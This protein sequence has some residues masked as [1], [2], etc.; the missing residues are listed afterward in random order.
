[1]GSFSHLKS[2]EYE[3]IIGKSSWR[4]SHQEIDLVCLNIWGGIDD[5][6]RKVSKDTFHIVTW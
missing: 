5:E 6:V 4:L 2:T 1:M 3:K